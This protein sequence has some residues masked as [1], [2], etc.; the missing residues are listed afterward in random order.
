MVLFVLLSLY[1]L[2][3]FEV[4]VEGIDK[5]GFNIRNIIDCIGA[6]VMIV[7][8]PI[9]IRFPRYSTLLLWI[10]AGWAMLDLIIRKY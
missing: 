6:F 8:L 2:S 1:G 9:T 7:S 4:S 5:F 3:A 10:I